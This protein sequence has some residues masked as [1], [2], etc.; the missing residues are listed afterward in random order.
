LRKMAARAGLHPVRLVM[1]EK[2]PSY[3]RVHNVLFYAMMIYERGVNRCEALAQ[4]R[5][6]IFAVLRKVR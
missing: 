2:E 6:N 1:V 4:L 3:G 5:S